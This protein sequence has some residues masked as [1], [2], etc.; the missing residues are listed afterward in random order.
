M[1]ASP[2]YQLRS[3]GRVWLS[4]R[5]GTIW[6]ICRLNCC[7]AAT[8]T[9]DKNYDDYVIFGL[10]ANLYA[11]TNEVKLE[12]CFRVTQKYPQKFF[13]IANYLVKLY[14]SVFFVHLKFQIC[15]RTEN[16]CLLTGAKI[17]QNSRN[18]FASHRKLGST[19]S[20]Q[21]RR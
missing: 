7:N 14:T 1:N 17:F 6:T 5:I 11:I 9:F 19:T 16:A 4:L 20:R 18:T 2:A 13:I 10:V 8:R 3:P 21:R 15:L 12:D